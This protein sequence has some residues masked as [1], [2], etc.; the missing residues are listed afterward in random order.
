[1][2]KRLG[3]DAASHLNV[4]ERMGLLTNLWSLLAAGK[5]DGDEY[6]VAMH[7]LSSDTDAN[8]LRAL[9]SELADLRETFITPDLEPLFAVYLREMFGPVLDRI[10]SSP[11]PDDS[12]AMED[13]R[14]QIL[15]WLSAY[16][17]D[18]NARAV[19]ANTVDQYLAGETSMSEAVDVALRSLPRWSGSD[20]FA[21]YRERI[22]ASKS[23]AERRSF[24][25]ALGTF[26]ELE[27]VSEVLDYVLEGEELRAGEVVTVLAG[28]FAAEKHNAMLLDWAMQHDAELRASLSDGQ[29]VAMPG[30]LMLCSTDTLDVIVD[31]YAAPE[32][33][34]G[35]I[36]G[37]LEEEVAEKTACAAFRQREQPSVRDY[38]NMN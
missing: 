19:V 14:P 28:L 2:L 29:M 13:L 20:L 26:R 33:F 24:V 3:D 32:R 1:M 17:E 30:R 10:G 7:S 31:F 25:R 35:G 27:V 6:L 5:L 38:L 8:V 15:L 34:V 18:D 21:S 11:L 9:V 22:V 23:P 36:E 37:E 4:R 16:G 12:N